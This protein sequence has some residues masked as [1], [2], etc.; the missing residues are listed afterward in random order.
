MPDAV[1]SAAYFVVSEAL[2]N[3]AKY[4]GA[5]S[6]VV[7]GRAE[8]GFVMVAVSDDGVGGADPSRGHRAA[9]PGRP[10]QR[11]GRAA[12]GGQRPRAGH[13][14]PGEDP[15]R[16]VVAEDSVLL[17]EGV[18]RLLAEAGFDVVAQAGDADDLR[19]RV[20][21]HKPDVAMVDVR[22]PPDHTDDGLRAALEIRDAPA[23]RPGCSCCPSTSRRATRWT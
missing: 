21:A 20:Y 2:T 14:R 23:R 15:V 19:R 5:S 8:N 11:P 7:A 10:P 22:M 18:V 17:R 4:A 1:E 13:H 3:V 16:V 9:R 6:A 12:R